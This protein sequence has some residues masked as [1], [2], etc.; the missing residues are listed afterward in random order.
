MDIVDQ[1]LSI[2]PL[3]HL[4]SA[5][6][7]L[8]LIC[9]FVK[10]APIN[11]RQL[12]GLVQSIAQLLQILDGEYRDGRLLRAQTSV[13]L[14][15]LSMFVICGLPWIL[16][17]HRSLLCSLLAEIGTFV[18]KPAS[19]EFLKLLFTKDQRI[20]QLEEYHGR[21]GTLI[22]SFQASCDIMSFIY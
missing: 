6:T 21:I 10:Q 1:C 14:A 5:F 11:Q 20:S 2:A 7:A 22:T 13:P 4:T 3:P 12:Q 19:S 17:I 9:T 8:K 16:N 15:N 18:Q